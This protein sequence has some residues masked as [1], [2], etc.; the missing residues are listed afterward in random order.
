MARI[1][2]WDATGGHHVERVSNKSVSKVS[3]SIRRTGGTI[4][5]VVHASKVG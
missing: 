3:R 1:E 4:S 2:W 5:K